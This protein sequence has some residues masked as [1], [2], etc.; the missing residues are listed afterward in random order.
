MNQPKKS[1]FGIGVLIGAALGSL[2]A[3][4]LSPKSGKENREMVLQKLE[5]I[6]KLLKNKSLDE[7]VTEIFGKVTDEGKHL[8][9][10]ARDEMNTRIDTLKESVEDIDKDKYTQIVDDVIER[11]KKEADATKERLAKLQDFLMNRW[12]KAQEM[13]TEDVKKVVTMSDKEKKA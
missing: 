12:G 2:A 11:L 13:A 5:D 1:R 8:Y 6:K 4:F 10:V 3:F 9:T 7:I